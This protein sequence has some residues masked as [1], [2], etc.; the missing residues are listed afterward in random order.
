MQRAA[1]VLA[2]CVWSLG[3][4][5]QLWRVEK[6]REAFFVLIFA[7]ED[8]EG[9]RFHFKGIVRRKS[10]CDLSGEGSL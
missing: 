3:R 8:N 7:I 4:G 5:G 9:K 10:E 2:A 1:G 6:L